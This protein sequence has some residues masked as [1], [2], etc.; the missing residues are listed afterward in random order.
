MAYKKKTALPI[1]P[2]DDTMICPEC[3][4]KFQ[5]AVCPTCGWGK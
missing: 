1:P 3:E 5:G 2:K 4:T